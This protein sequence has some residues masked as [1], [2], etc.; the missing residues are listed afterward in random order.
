MFSYWHK[1]CRGK[2]TPGFDGNKF[3]QE[4]SIENCMLF[5]FKEGF[6]CFEW[7]HNPTRTRMVTMHQGEIIYSKWNI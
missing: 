2:E 1:D 4:E 6:K 5:V 3:I 7:A